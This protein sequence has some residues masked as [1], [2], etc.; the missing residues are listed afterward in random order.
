MAFAPNGDLWIVGNFTSADGSDGDY[1]CY[2]NGAAFVRVGSTELSAAARSIVFDSKGMPIISGDFTNAGGNADADRIARWNGSQWESLGTGFAT[3]YAKQMIYNKDKLYCVGTFTNAGG[4]SLH[5]KIAIYADGSWGSFDANLPGAGDI[6]SVCITRDNT[7]YVG[8]VFSTTADG[9]A[10]VSG[11]ATVTSSSGSANSYPFIQI[12]G[13][14]VLQSITNYTTGKTIEFDG[15]TLQ[16]GEWVNLQCNPSRIKFQ[17]GWASRGNLLR[18]VVPGSDIADFY[19]K[20]GTNHINVLMPS[21]YTAA[22]GG[23]I[24]WYP[25]FW[26]IEGAKHD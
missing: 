1:V 7:I 4:I 9:N 16:A 24:H 18:Y 6:Y 5:D 22:S 13:P 15:L 21:G 10:I 19:I 3:G 12:T 20:P 11:D 17:S 25:K 2:W 14:G 26:S 23:M 8:G